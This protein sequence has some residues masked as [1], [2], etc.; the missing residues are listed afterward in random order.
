MK[1][2]VAITIAGMLIPIIVRADEPKGT[3]EGTWTV[4]DMERSGKKAPQQLLQGGQFRVVIK[5]NSLRM[6]DIKQGEG[7]TFTIDETKK[8]RTIDAVFMEGPKEDV[9]RTALGIYELDGDNLKIAWR[10][11][12]GP[13]P[14]EFSSLK[15]VRTSELW[16][17]KRAQ[18]N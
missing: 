18:V 7:A 11:D 2:Y 6:S 1:L 5:A 8:P 9:R 16:V 4:V 17:L 10:K 12:G 14:Q 3:I 13:R 15:G